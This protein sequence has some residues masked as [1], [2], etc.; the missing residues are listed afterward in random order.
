MHE[1]FAF[2]GFKCMQCNEWSWIM[3]TSWNHSLY[4]CVFIRSSISLGN[5]KNWYCNF[6]HCYTAVFVLT[7]HQLLLTSVAHPL[8]SDLDDSSNGEMTSEEESGSSPIPEEGD[9]G[10]AAGDE[11]GA[12]AIGT[13]AA[14]PDAEPETE[15]T[16]SLPTPRRASFRD[17]LYFWQQLLTLDT[18]SVR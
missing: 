4:Q 8:P 1:R 13:P 14:S 9:T 18:Q 7:V 15:P 2:N 16:A 10:A 3:T 17:Y 5:S 11:T 12:A 6:R